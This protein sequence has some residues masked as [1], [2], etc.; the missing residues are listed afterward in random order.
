MPSTTAAVGHQG[1]HGLLENQTGLGYSHPV[2]LTAVHRLF[3]RVTAEMVTSL[4]RTHPTTFWERNPNVAFQWIPGHMG[5]SGN[6]WAYRLADEVHRLPAT[7]TSAPDHPGTCRNLQTLRRYPYK[8]ARQKRPR[9][10]H[11]GLKK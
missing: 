5:I 4:T 11:Q 2:R 3:R 10:R 8:D 9:C 1:G 7:V 6:V